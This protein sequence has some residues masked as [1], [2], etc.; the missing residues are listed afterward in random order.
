MFQTN[1]DF[2]TDKARAIGEPLR[3]VMAGGDNENIMQG[4]F[5]AESQGF[6]KPILMGNAAR[7][8]KMLKDLCFFDRQYTVV[9][10]PDDQDV[11][12]AAIDYIKA[13]K[14]DMLLRGNVQT[15]DFLM[16]ILDKQNDLIKPDSLLSHVCLLKV[17]EYPRILAVADV[18]IVVEP[19]PEQRKKITQNVVR[20]LNALGYERPNVALMSLIEK[21]AFH[22]KDTVEA[23]NIVH[24]H[25]MHPIAECN[26]VGPI[27][28]DLIISKEAAR[29][30]HYD[31][32]LCG[33]FDAIITPNL[34]AGNLLIKS[35]QIHGHAA[36]LGVIVGAKIPVAITSRSEPREQTYLSIAACAALQQHK[37][38]WNL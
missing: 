6:A 2:I 23:S 35:A 10:V 11:V 16:P 3:V 30:K 33:E 31:C 34:L 29:L 21:P 1:F 36:S 25:S 37:V 9:D 8:D 22:M 19:N 12:Q 13:G 17:P 18:S 27:A 38:T 20:M 28:Y 7:I 5:Q 24:S 26:I 15:R 32:D 4:L 14:G